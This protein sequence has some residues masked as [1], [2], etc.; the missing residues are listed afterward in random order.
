MWG[1]WGDD[2]VMT[3]AWAVNELDVEYWRTSDKIRDLFKIY[4]RE[5]FLIILWDL[6]WYA[7]VVCWNAFT[8]FESSN[9][10]YEAR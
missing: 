6:G 4:Q 1:E 8:G 5:H 9:D 2:G 10:E 3:R 7:N